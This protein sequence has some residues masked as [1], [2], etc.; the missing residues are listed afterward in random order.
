MV[1]GFLS[2]EVSAD[3]L[4][5]EADFAMW[6]SDSVNRSWAYLSKAFLNQ[7]DPSLHQEYLSRT[8]QEN[9]NSTACKLSKLVGAGDSVVESISDHAV[10]SSLTFKWLKMDRLQ[11]SGQL[12]RLAEESQNLIGEGELLGFAQSSLVRSSW[13]LGKLDF[14]AGV[15]QSS[16]GGWSSQA[17][18]Q[19]A[20]WMCFEETQRNCESRPMKSCELLEK[21]VDQSLQVPPESWVAL[22]LDRN[23]KKSEPILLPVELAVL[24]SGRPSDLSQMLQFLSWWEEERNH[25]KSWHQVYTALTSILIS[26]AIFS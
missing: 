24:S 25:E 21:A 20:T 9:S 10:N 2:K 7:S 6:T 1:A 15:F 4:E 5:S 8:C 17:Q 11:K 12:D 23:C 13:M 18:L 26:L 14:A 16:F 3:C 22:Q 19:E